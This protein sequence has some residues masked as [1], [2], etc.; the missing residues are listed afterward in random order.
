MIKF[1]KADEVITSIE[2]LKK[3][4]KEEAQRNKEYVSK[5][6]YLYGEDAIILF[7]DKYMNVSRI[8]WRIQSAKGRLKN[9][10]LSGSSKFVYIAVLELSFDFLDE[11]EYMSIT[12]IEKCVEFNGAIFEV[13]GKYKDK[14]FSFLLYGEYINTS[15]S[16]CKVPQKVGT[17]TDKKMQ[18]WVDYLKAEKAA[19]EEAKNARKEE[20]QSFKQELCEI[21]GV[22]MELL[23]GREEGTIY[24]K[25]FNV[26]WY[27]NEKSGSCD[28][29][30]RMLWN[31]DM[32]TLR[33]LKEK[34]L[35]Y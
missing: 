28:L 12:H 15:E 2:N 27:A 34:G 6:A 26:A 23:E 32:N 14:T 4:V 18:A 10:K 20:V 21:T 33:T 19:Q 17:V 5:V 3:E 22:S 29:S 9:L 11:K 8:D 1:I 13:M 16:L 24:G 25:M 31:H 30:I 35:L 7:N